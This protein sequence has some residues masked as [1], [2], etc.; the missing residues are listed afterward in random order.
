MSGDVRVL[1]ASD[2]PAAQ[3]DALT[4]FAVRWRAHTGS[5]LPAEWAAAW[6][7]LAWDIHRARTGPEPRR[8]DP[9]ADVAAWGAW[10]A[11]AFAH[12]GRHQAGA[13]LVPPA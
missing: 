13:P 7:P 1:P 4:E 9:F 5:P 8:H 3:V 2:A 11:G 12:P 10:M 6:W